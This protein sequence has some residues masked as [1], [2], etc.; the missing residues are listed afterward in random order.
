VLTHTPAYACLSTA[1]RRVRSRHEPLRG[2]C[3]LA[4]SIIRHTSQGSGRLGVLLA[5]RSVLKASAERADVATDGRLPKA[6]TPKTTDQVKFP[7]SLCATNCPGR[8]NVLRRDDVSDRGR[9]VLQLDDN[10]VFDGVAI[11]T[12]GDVG[13]QYLQV[14]RGCQRI[15][16]R[17]RGERI[18]PL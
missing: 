6:L 15:S 5:R 10:T 11:F 2:H 9:T 3:P 14:L 7:F 1:L 16:D 12:H 4:W 13:A 8:V 17:C 18:C